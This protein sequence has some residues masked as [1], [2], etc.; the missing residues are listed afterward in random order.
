MAAPIINRQ[1]LDFL[2]YDWLG[3][4]AL[5]ERERYTGHGR[6]T[7]D[8]VLDLSERLAADKFLSHYKRSDQEEP[9]LTPDGVRVLPEIRE[10]VRAY[11]DAGLLAAPFDSALGGM[12]LPELVHT[13]S[14]A[15]F[16]A[17]NIATSAYP[18][19]TIGNARLIVAFGTKEQIEVFARPEIEGRMLG[20]MCLSE[21]QAGSSLADIR[22]RAVPEQN[23][24]GAVCVI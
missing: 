22:T 9:E 4:E 11:A 23:A 21:P 1:D 24:G 7:V 3:L 20:T 13:A 5:L 17:A 2:L 12:Q 16:M 8:A 19:L 10:A 15:L 14:M 18:M 6:G